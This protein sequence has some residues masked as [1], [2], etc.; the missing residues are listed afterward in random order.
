[1]AQ[2][3]WKTKHNS[4]A[5]KAAIIVILIFGSV[6]VLL[7]I[8]AN[9]NRYKIPPRPPIQSNITNDNPQIFTYQQ[10]ANISKDNLLLINSNYKVPNNIS[11]DLVKVSDYVKTLNTDNLLDKEALIMLKEMFDSAAKMGYDEFRVT[12]GYRT[13]EYQQSLYDSAED[14]SIVA[15]PDY[16]E[17]QTGLAVDISYNGVNIGNSR[18]GTWFADNSYKYGFIL[19]YPQNK[20]NITKIPY[21][22]WHY[23]Y[24]GQPHSYLCYE[25]NLCFEEYI[26]YLKENK[27]ISITI[28]AIEYTVY[29]LS[30]IDETIKIPENHSYSSS[31]DNTGGIILTIW[32]IDPELTVTNIMTRTA[33][34]IEDWSFDLGILMRNTCY[35]ELENILIGGL[36]AGQSIAEFTQAI[37]DSGIRDEYYKA[38]TVAVTEVLRAHSVAQQEAIIQN[39]AVEGKEWRHTG[40]HKNK[41]R[42]N[43]VAMDGV[44]VEK[45]EPFTLAGA[46]GGIY[47]PMYPRDTCLPPG[48]AINCHCIHRGVVNENVLGLSLDERKRMQEEIIAA[49]NGEWERELDAQNRAKAGIE[50]DG[51]IYPAVSREQQINPEKF[52]TNPENNSII[53]TGGKDI[54]LISEKAQEII[55]KQKPIDPATIERVKNSLENKGVSLEQSDEMDKWLISKGA[56]AVTFSDG[57]IVLHT[58]ASASGLFEEL[59]HYGQVKSGRAI[60]GNDKNNLL[61]EIEAKEQLIKYQNAY[62]ITDYEIEVLTNVLG[63]YKILLENLMKGSG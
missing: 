5:I 34:W 30:G 38:R 12:E 45:D 44:I 17:H 23:R 13:R 53:D 24:I 22:P 16:S 61:M 10:L 3:Q 33:S 25:N 9:D 54:M 59:I 26:D 42:E 11:V 6:W 56:E 50:V 28:N 18:Q 20:E 8:L 57:T 60:A 7:N 35:K 40:S 37:L 4:P 19:R 36:T 21:E 43:H 15:L 49:D 14:K 1:M 41:P 48:E 47:Y 46:D 31:F 27:K 39:P 62:K 29:Y 63:D 2:R 51:E 32:Q 55:E 52:L 58:N